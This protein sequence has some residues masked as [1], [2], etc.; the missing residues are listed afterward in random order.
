M[1][2]SELKLWNYVRHLTLFK[3]HIIGIRIH[4]V[5]SYVNLQEFTTHLGCKYDLAS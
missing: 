3:L 5:K 1:K 4:K 2:S